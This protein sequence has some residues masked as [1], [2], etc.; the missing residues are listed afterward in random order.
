MVLVVVAIVSLVTFGFTFSQVNQEKQRLEADIEYRS[1]LLANALK[2]PV[3]TSLDNKKQT[4]AI[5]DRFTND[6]RI[7]GVGIVDNINSLIASSSTLVEEIP[8]SQRLA[9]DAMDSSTSDSAFVT[10]RGQRMHVFAEPIRNPEG[11]GVIGAILVVQKASYIDQ[12]ISDVWRRNVLRLIIQVTI[13][14]LA[15]LIVLRLLVQRPLRRLLNSLR[16]TKNGGGE[17]GQMYKSSLFGPVL[18]EFSSIQKSLVRAKHAAREAAK[19]S[20]EQLDTPWTAERLHE[21][22]KDLIKNR[23]IV[24]VSNREPYVHYKDGNDIKYYIPTGGMITALNPM[25]QACG[26]LWIAH[27]SGNADREVVD[28]DDKIG[29]PPDDPSYTLKRVWLTKEEEEGY[30]EGFSN[31]GLWPLCHMVHTRPTFRQSDW[32]A[33]QKVNQKF[34]DAVLKEIKGKKNP[35]VIIQDYHFSLLPRLI[36]NARPDAAVCIFW[37]IPWPNS[38]AF[39]I[40]PWKKEILD[41][42]LGAD[43]IGFH[44]QL[45]CNNFITTVSKELEALIDVEHSSITKNGHTSYIAPFPI[46]VDF[47][48]R[49]LGRQELEAQ[50]Q[51]AK[52]IRE[53]LGVKTQYLGVGVERLDYTKGLLERVKAIELFLERY[54]QYRGEFTFVQ[55]ADPSRTG[56][57]EYQEFEQRFTEEVERVNNAYKQNDWKP[58]ILIKEHRNYDYLYNLYRAA[59]ICLVTPLHDGMNLVA[60]E[61]IAARNDERGVL[62]LS[63]YVGAAQELREALIINPYDGQQTAEAIRTGLE[64]QPAEQ[65]RRMRKLRNTVKNNNVYRW[66]A[67]IIKRIAELD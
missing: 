3:S 37:H 13:F 34:A 50:A 14:S 66:A 27:G 7:A 60:K 35:I 39:S 8:V 56:I 22:T 51:A 49:K 53:E 55:I 18:Q 16:S 9:A 44:T 19:T 11:Q 48:G 58:I 10:Y 15:I 25:M 6:Q 64:M 26:G 40:C 46:S 41:G 57:K 2:A 31:R 63:Q 36:K 65:A 62:I 43:V 33:Y 54:P 20:L 17:D 21:F 47:T 42:L 24:A 4:Q 38:E 28:K 12:H 59:D 67:E 52:K 5:V 30:Y 23:T 45:F 29:V 61:F 1:S 32:E